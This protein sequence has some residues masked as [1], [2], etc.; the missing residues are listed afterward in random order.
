MDNSVVTAH[1]NERPQENRMSRKLSPIYQMRKFNNWLKSVLIFLHTQPGYSVLDLCCGKGGDLHKFAQADIITYVACDTADISVK[2]LANRYN[3]MNKPPFRPILLVGDCFDVRVSDF[4]PPQIMFD[5]VSCQFAIHYAFETESRVRG[6]LQNVTDRLKPGGFFIGTTVD[7]NVVVRKVRAVTDL[8]IGNSV[9]RVTFDQKFASKRF[10]HGTPYG[11]RYNFKLD[12]SVDDCPEFLVHFPSFQRLAEEYDLE[13]VM[14]NNF[15]DF[16]AE[17][18]SDKY[19]RYRDLLHS[20]RVLNEEFTIEPD[21]WDAIYLYTAFAF[22][23]KGE[24]SPGVPTNE[25]QRAEVHSVSDSE[26]IMMNST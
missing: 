13:L 17:F 19:P 26:I 12:Q 21:Q 25:I 15:H 24:P 8:S 6:L 4:L 18:S 2:E 3:S 1:Y 14:L 23:R 20:M 16:F 11:F 7:A 5:I 9:Y 22:R 10:A